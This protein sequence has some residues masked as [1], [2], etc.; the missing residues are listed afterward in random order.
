M[1][2]IKKLTLANLPTPVEKHKF[3]GCTF[4]IKRDDLSGFELSGNKIRKLEYLLLDAKRKKADYIFTCGGEQSNHARAT[5]IASAALAFKPQLF[6]WGK[7]RK[8]PE[9]NLFLD[10]LIGA[11]IQF[12]S[13]RE[14]SNV[15]KIMI[16]KKEM[17]EAKGHKVY[18]VPEGG[19]SL[20]G[21]WGYI[22]F[23]DELNMQLNLKKFKG[24]L[25]AAGSGGTSA[26]LLVGA[27][28]KGLNLKIFAVNVFYS[29]KIIKEKILN[30]AEECVKK[31]KLGIQINPDNLEILDGY[32]SEGYKKIDSE[33]IEVIKSFFKQSG[34]LFDPAYTG[35]AFYA[36]NEIFLNEKKHSNILFV[37]TGG[38]FG[39]FAKKKNYLSI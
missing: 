38:T 36:Y 32:S 23:I 21:I 6:L 37:H 3:N 28:L 34:I 20:L 19:S 17:L 7:E 31:Y 18:I 27:K 10:H 8:I 33:K 25:T 29:K 26:G 14:Y 35:K 2:T 12:L 11:E 16:Q 15:N 5:A 24:I 13:R 4:Y 1:R 39:V 9:G 22:N 30:L